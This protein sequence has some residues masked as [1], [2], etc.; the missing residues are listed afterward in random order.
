V[1]CAR[2]LIATAIKQKALVVADRRGTTP[3]HLAAGAGHVQCVQLADGLA[4]EEVNLVDRH[5]RSHQLP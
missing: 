4:N 2:L 3:L 1:E 5:K